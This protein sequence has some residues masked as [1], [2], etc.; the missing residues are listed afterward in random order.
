M[1]GWSL[2]VQGG[3]PRCMRVRPFMIQSL[4]WERRGRAAGRKLAGPV[5]PGSKAGLE[6]VREL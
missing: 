1:C 2:Q 6:G 3:V 4:R 5:L